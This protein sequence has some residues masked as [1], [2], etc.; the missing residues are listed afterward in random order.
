M[1]TDP[2]SIIV[3]A[4]FAFAAT[5]I[6]DIFLL[7][8]WFAQSDRSISR[9]TIVAGQYLGFAGLVGI[10]LLGLLGSLVIPQTWMGLLGLLPIGIGV[11]K[12]YQGSQ[13]GVATGPKVSEAVRPNLTGNISAHAMV[14]QVTAITFANGGDNL[15]IYTPLFAS[16]GYSQIVTTLAVFFVLV[17]VWCGLGY[18]FARQKVVDTALSRY[19]HRLVP[20]VLI[21]L[22]G[23]ILMESETYRLLIPSY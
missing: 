19:G 14:W 3:K 1:E 6:D 4:A 7:T 23:I 10:S 13:K 5:N 16:S 8:L 15:G 21:A 11:Q 9:F 22:G 20:L 18:W 2:I 12:W 17:A